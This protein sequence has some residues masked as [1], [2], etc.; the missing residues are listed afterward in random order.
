MRDGKAL[1]HIPEFGGKAY[2]AG[3]KIP[4]KVLANVSPQ[5]L[6]A[7]VDNFKIEIEGM[8]PSTGGSGGIAHLTARLD[9]QADQIK[10]LV[11]A[12]KELSGRLS[13]LEG[14]KAP[15]ENSRRA[16]RASGKSKE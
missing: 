16:V 4:G 11:A 8:E 7:L 2:Q 5:V 10:A 1:T 9:A 14:G 13:A 3:E 12:N 15:A 6:K